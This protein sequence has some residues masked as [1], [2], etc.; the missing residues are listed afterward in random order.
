M[1]VDMTNTVHQQT[2]QNLKKLDDF[3]KLLLLITL[4]FCE[5]M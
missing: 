3:F 2:D 5:R 1:E 4:D